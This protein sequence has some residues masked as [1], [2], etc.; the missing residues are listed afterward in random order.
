MTLPDFST[1]PNDLRTLVQQHWRAFSDSGQSLPPALS[2][3]LMRVWAGSDYVAE[4]MIRRPALTE[5]LAQ[6]GRLSGRLDA[7]QLRDELRQAL[8]DVADEADLQ[9]RLRHLRHCHMAR[10]IWRDLIGD[11][12]RSLYAD[13]VHDLSLLADSL[14]DVA[15]DVLFRWATA[16]T[17]RP[18]TRRAIRFT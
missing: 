9:R 13:T 6:S 4:Q 2:S 18:P 17:V 14:I 12:G 7:S 8:L 15:L 11:Q 3:G 10:I 1:L 5:W 16:K